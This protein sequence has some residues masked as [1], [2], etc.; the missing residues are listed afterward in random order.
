MTGLARM[1]ALPSGLASAAAEGFARR[2]R[3]EQGLL[4][5][6][7]VLGVAGALV[8]WGWRPLA[9]ARADLVAG[10]SRYEQALSVLARLPAAQTTAGVTDPRP[11][12]EILTD[13]A[14][15]YQVTIHRLESRGDAA[16]LVLDDVAYDA[17]ILWLDALETD[18]GVRLSALDLTRRPEAGSVSAK[19]TLDR[20][21]DGGN[22]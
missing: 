19:L 9:A 17:L 15:G 4:A 10:I 1:M 7:L 8:Q 20:V 13:S 21:A 2:S 12:P 16:D 6:C 22:E 3:R 18:Y 14:A 5:L 11:L